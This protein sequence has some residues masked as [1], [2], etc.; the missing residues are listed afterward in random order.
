MLSDFHAPGCY[1]PGLFD[2]PASQ[3]KGE[4]LMQVLDQINR[5]GRGKV[6][7]AGQGMSPEWS[8]KREHLSPS[9]TTRW[10]DIPCVR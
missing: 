4:K 8:M 7:F 2:S 3:P 10:E 5:S 9:Y 1:Q 6:F